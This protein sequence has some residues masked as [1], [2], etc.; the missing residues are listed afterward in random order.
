MDQ[1]GRKPAANRAAAAPSIAPLPP[2]GDFVQF[3]EHQS[4]LREM[5]VDRLDAEWQHGPTARCSPLETLNAVTKG[6]EN[7]KRRGVRMSF[8]Q[9]DWQ[10]Y[11]PFLFVL[12]YRVNRSVPP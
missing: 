2:P 11:G 10:S 8:P 9:R 12:G 7:R 5:P 1:I 6:R 3:A 4:A